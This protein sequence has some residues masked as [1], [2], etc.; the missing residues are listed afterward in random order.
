[1]QFSTKVI[2]KIDISILPEFKID[3]L[4]KMVEAFFH[5]RFR[6][7]KMCTHTNTGKIITSAEKAFSVSALINCVRVYYLCVYIFSTM[8][9]LYI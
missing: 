5:I 4:Y 9:Y 2:N 6:L 7:I 8:K 3:S 1:M